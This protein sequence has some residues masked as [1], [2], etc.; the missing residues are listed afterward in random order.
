MFLRKGQRAAEAFPQLDARPWN[1]LVAQQ[2]GE[3]NQHFGVL[4]VQVERVAC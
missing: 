4:H 2:L 1:P 3:F